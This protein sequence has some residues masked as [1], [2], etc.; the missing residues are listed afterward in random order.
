MFLGEKKQFQIPDKK[1][2]FLIKRTTHTKEPKF[3]EMFTEVVEPKVSVKITKAERAVADACLARYKAS[4]TSYKRNTNTNAMKKSK[5]AKFSVKKTSKSNPDP[6]QENQL[7]NVKLAPLI[8]KNLKTKP[9]T[10]TAEIDVLSGAQRKTKGAEADKRS[11][12]LISK[13]DKSGSSSRKRSKSTSS[14]GKG[15]T[16][17]K[18]Q[19][20]VNRCLSPVGK[21]A[22]SKTLSFSDKASKNSKHC[23]T[24]Q[25]DSNGKKFKLMYSYVPH[26][27]PNRLENIR[28]KIGD[29]LE[30]V[31]SHFRSPTK[32]QSH[33]A[34]IKL[35][36]AIR[37][38]Q[39]NRKEL[40]FAQRNSSA[41][42][43][44]R[45]RGRPR[46][47]ISTHAPLPATS[48]ESS[49]ELPPTSKKSSVELSST[50]N[51][52]NEQLPSSPSNKVPITPSPTLSEATRTSLG[53]SL[54]ST[55]TSGSNLSS[56]CTSSTSSN[57][58]NL[59]SFRI[60]K[61]KSVTLGSVCDD[62]RY[63]ANNL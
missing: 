16:S 43:I 55:Q 62:K 48:N 52:K 13:V 51:E 53:A 29:A 20:K 30:T 36:A 44:R 45:N 34:R 49:M 33:E 21:G 46:K 37:T 14:T 11:V 17:G 22:P 60:S 32:H 7:C 54:P 40:H 4:S 8:I 56:V 61:V 15:I 12:S 58:Q 23:E 59:K 1:T 28:L 39:C 57:M 3:M 2:K 31:K 18:A 27:D 41:G 25:S 35:A 63:V 42:V 26:K 6:S 47:S 10:Q 5:P 19:G 24:F 50:F 38:L 9:C